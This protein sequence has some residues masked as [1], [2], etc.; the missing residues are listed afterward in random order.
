MKLYKYYNDG[1]LDE[2]TCY[3]DSYLLETIFDNG[4]FLTKKEATVEYIGRLQSHRQSLE[5]QADKIKLS[6]KNITKQIRELSK[7]VL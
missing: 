3:D 6:V 7:E 2:M 5:D 1:S 4:Y